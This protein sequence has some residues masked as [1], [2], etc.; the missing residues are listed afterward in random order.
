MSAPASSGQAAPGLSMRGVHAEPRANEVGLWRFGGAGRC[1]FNQMRGRIGWRNG[2]P[3]RGIVLFGKQNSLDRNFVGSMG[4]KRG[5][6]V[7]IRQRVVAAVSMADY[8]CGF[9]EA[10]RSR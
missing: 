1:R 6:E 5:G 7:G 3:T 8:L 4:R 10:S 9:C 2:R